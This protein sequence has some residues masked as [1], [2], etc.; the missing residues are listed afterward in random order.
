MPQI[1]NITVKDG[2]TDVVFTAQMP[3]SGSIPA[4]WVNR[5]G[6]RNL[7]KNLTTFVRPRSNASLTTDKTVVRFDMP[8]KDPIT[9]LLTRSYTGKLEVLLPVS[10]TDAEASQ[11]IGLLLN[12]LAHADIKDILINALPAV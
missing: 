10:G 8:V 3:Q 6:A 2:T 12:L 9:G 7:Q 11:F 1:K 4:K 5:D